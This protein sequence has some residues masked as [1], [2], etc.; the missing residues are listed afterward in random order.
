MG[1]VET[2]LLFMLIVREPSFWS[3]VNATRLLEI[4]HT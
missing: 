2:I 1:V 4:V 3:G